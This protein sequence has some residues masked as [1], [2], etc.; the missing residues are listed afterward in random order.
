MR[1]RKSKLQKISILLILI[2]SC[3]FWAVP[4]RGISSPELDDYTVS[5]GQEVTVSGEDV[6][7]GSTVHIYWSLVK[8]SFSSGSGF[9]TSTVGKPDGSFET[10][11]TIPDSI[12]GPN[13]VWVKDI[14][15]GSTAKSSVVTVQPKI[16]LTPHR[17]LPDDSI[18]VEGVGFGEDY[19][20]DLRF[21]NGSISLSLSTSPT[22][23]STND[24]GSFDAEFTV[25]DLSMGDYNV[26]ATDEKGNMTTADFTIGASIKLDEYEEASGKVI[27]IEGVGFGSFGSIDEGEIMMDGVEVPIKGNSISVNSKG[28]FDGEIIIPSIEPG[29][30]TII[31]TDGDVWAD[32]DFTVTGNTKIELSPTAGPP[33]TELTVEGFNF[34]NIDETEVEI[35]FGSTTYTGETSSNGEFSE[36]FSIPALVSGTYTVTATDENGLTAEASFKV[37]VIFV[38]FSPKSGGSGETVIVTGT[39]F[40]PGDFDAYFGDIRVIKDGRVTS[41]KNINEQFFVPTLEPG[42]YTLRVVDEEDN[43]ASDTFTLL[44]KTSLELS[45]SQA[46]VGK[47]VTFTG[48]YFSEDEGAELEWEVYNSTWS[49][50]ISGDLMHDDEVAEVTEHGNFTA[51]WEIPDDMALGKAYSINAT[52]ENGNW[53]S[54][55]LTISEKSIQISTTQSSYTLGDTVTFNI[56]SGFKEVDSYLRIRDPDMGLYFKSTFEEDDWEESGEQWYVPVR[57]QFDDVNGYPFNIPTTAEAGEW[58]W[59]L[60]DSEDDLLAIGVFEVYESSSEGLSQRIRD[61]ESAVEDLNSEFNQRMDDIEDQMSAIGDIAQDAKEAAEEAEDAASS[62]EQKAEDAKIAAEDAKDAVDKIVSTVN[63]VR[64]LVYAAIGASIVAAVAGIVSLYQRAFIK[65]VIRPSEPTE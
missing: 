49:M 7:A 24:Y 18:E 31:V 22:T 41:S 5:P 15:S 54:T 30:Y 26:E 16:T 19:E 23:I 45:S 59:Y 3:L 6:T 47:T 48:E 9:L 20:V 38:V 34:T 65:P 25:P 58:Q 11:I 17:G 51:S 33:G 8:E 53:G 2:F 14:S 56:R 29:D 61:L 52:D 36:S 60:Y 21:Y 57:A 50:D 42:T 44:Y 39:G 12:S 40:E 43:E 63:E 64:V 35:E 1:V 37:G 62:V 27:D 28:E 4:V 13:Y 46:P 32:A 10:E 55:T